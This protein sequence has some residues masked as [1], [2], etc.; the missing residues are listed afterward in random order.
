SGD[1]GIAEPCHTSEDFYLSAMDFHP[2]FGTVP[3][4]LIILFLSQKLF[5]Q[6]ASSSGIIPAPVSFSIT[7]GSFLL[8]KNTLL[9]AAD[10]D[11]ISSAKIFNQYLKRYFG[12]ELEI[13]SNSCAHSPK[14]ILAHTT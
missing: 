5:S 3:R 9:L 2:R 14:I 7:K 8:T 1:F 13:V 10:S 12:F 4:L 6:P 11:C